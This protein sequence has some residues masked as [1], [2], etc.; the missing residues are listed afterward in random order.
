MVMPL[1][2][3][4]ERPIKSNSEDAL[5]RAPFIQRLILSLIDS[6][7][8]KATGVVIGIVAPWGSG[9]SSIL[10]LLEEGIAKKYTDA[11]IVRFDPWLISG[12]NDLITEFLRELI[13]TINSEPKLAAKLKALTKTL[14]EYCLQLAPLA[15]F[16]KP[17]AGE[18]IKRIFKFT[19]E[20]S[21][22]EEA[23]SLKELRSQL[24]REIKEISVPIVVL[25]D[26]IDRVEDQEIQS[27]AQLVRSVMDFPEISYVL[28]YD[29][30]RVVQALGAGASED[31]R[32]ERGRAYLEKIVQLQI[33][34]PIT[35]DNEVKS[36]LESELK[37]L[38][39]DVDLPEN[40]SS[41]ERYQNLMNVLIGGAIRT[42]RD[43]K[44]FVGTYHILREMLKGEVDWIDLLAFSALSIKAP[45]TVDQIYKEP[46]DFLENP[47]SLRAVMRRF[48]RGKDIP[49]EE[50]LKKLLPESDQ[51]NEAALTILPFIFPYLAKTPQREHIDAICLRRPL[52]S[53]LRLG[54]LPNSLSREEI[55]SIVSQTTDDIEN[56]L[57]LMLQDDKLP[58]F[59]DRLG[60][61]YFELKNINHVA[62][63]TA[64][65]RILKKPDCEWR[66]SYQPMYEI[67]RNFANV[68][69]SACKE[70]YDFRTT[71][72][73]VFSNLRNQG[74][75]ELTPMWLRSHFFVYGL[76]R[77]ELRGGEEW[78]LTREQA[79]ALA[80][81][82]AAG[83][84]AE[85]IAGRLI[86]CRWDM[87]TVY[88]LIDMGLWDDQCRALFDQKLAD[89]AALDGI[90]LMLY[91]SYY[92][93]DYQTVSSMCSHDLFVE[94]IKQRLDANNPPLHET[95]RV[96]MDKAL[97]YL[98]RRAIEEEIPF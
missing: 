49:K 98:P 51:E 73:T 84:R 25:I 3:Q 75:A 38:Q 4:P 20:Y 34:L 68:L 52:L 58:Q 81:E 47:S 76:F 10:N 18:V 43:V 33:L 8:E 88:T 9:K 21:S 30:K 93:T 83:W 19:K 66:T 7:T 24:M 50:L 39:S 17:G 71:A 72:A 62:F 92:S 89:T 16:V 60:E 59:I 41:I 61:I 31:K 85:H 32:E 56:H 95:V 65:G 74:E 57:R 63:W 36:L 42:P 28:A 14:S 11:V 86:P 22:K 54:L 15:N 96:A 80:R 94:R 23:K 53:T 87:Q 37:S 45:A 77:R 46:D 1:S 29:A 91:G 26:E 35:F 97:R 90:T 64:V 12:R 79:E 69:E 40:F 70:N 82:M 6:K 67:V 44:R 27:I 48:T 78:F 5:G 13:G 55:N 2:D